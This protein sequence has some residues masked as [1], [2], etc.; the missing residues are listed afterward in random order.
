MEESRRYAPLYLF[1]PLDQGYYGPYKKTETAEFQIALKK[2]DPRFLGK[3]FIACHSASVPARSLMEITIVDDDIQ[4]QVEAYQL[5]D[6]KHRVRHVWFAKEDYPDGKIPLP[7]LFAYA[8]L[9]W[10]RTDNG[11]AAT[12][13]G[14]LLKKLTTHQLQAKLPGWTC[15]NLRGDYLQAYED[16]R[17]LPDHVELRPITQGLRTKVRK[18]IPASTPPLF[19]VT[20]PATVRELPASVQEVPDDVVH[21]PCCAHAGVKRKRPSM[22]L[23]SMAIALEDVADQLKVLSGAKRRLTLAVNKNKK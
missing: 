22:D 11:V 2:V 16:L 21:C 13:Y 23:T 3:V 9:S 20:T 18:S 15:R 19:E 6:T 5:V 8:V 14:R 7:S 17:S 10:V 1:A 12:G 4:M